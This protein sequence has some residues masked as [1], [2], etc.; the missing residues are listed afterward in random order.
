MSDTGQ[1]VV[2]RTLEAFEVDYLQGWT[3]AAR[4]IKLGVTEPDRARMFGV[5]IAA[6][7]MGYRAAWAE[8]GR[9]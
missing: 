1:T 3:H 6:W 9:R 4:E 8:S 7:T 2:L 5:A